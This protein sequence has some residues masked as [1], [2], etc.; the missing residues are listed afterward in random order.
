M[1]RIVITGMGIISPIGNDITT[2]WNNLK[3]GVCGIQRIDT[4][5]TADLS[6][7]VAG[8][9]K[10]F[11]PADY[12]IDPATARKAD[13]YT[14]YALAA[15]RQAM[16]ESNPGVDP[17]RL[18][19]YVGSGIGGIHTFI[20]EC[21]K[22]LE[23]GPNRVSPLF[24]PTMIGNIAAGNIAIA[25]NAQGPCLPVVTACATSTHAIGEA[26]RAIL[27][28]YAD[29]VITGGAEAAVVP[30]A[31]GGFNNSR[32][33]SRAEDPKRASIPFDANRQGFVMAEG[34]GIVVLEEYEHAIQRGAVI[35]AELTGYGNTCDA[36]HY[37]A[38]RP[39]GSA[40]AK[41]MSLALSNS[42]FTPED[43]LYI[44]AHGTGTPLNDPAETMAIKLALGEEQARKA[45]ISSTK[46]M[47][48]HM[49]GAAG[50]AEIIAS[51]LALKE[52][53]VPPTVGLENPD[54]QCDLDYVPGKARKADITIALSNSLGFGGHNASVALRKFKP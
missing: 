32:A 12:G 29:A 21:K 39:D 7:K 2:Y 34:A 50:A 49:L 4:F 41:A 9:V 22:Y 45:L 36:Y 51:A 13:L 53:V 14:L 18:G 54:P 10:N 28:G 24:I 33:L 35:Y 11:N 8:L 38:P 20:T 30:L 25:H 47:T 46:S 31:V 40:A 26:Y 27:H 1:R 17:D 3:A 19:V 5:D 48:G 6:V 52:G 43:L 23:S 15:A 42:A 37:T 44:N 16:E